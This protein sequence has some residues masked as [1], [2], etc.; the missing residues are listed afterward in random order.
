MEPRWSSWTGGRESQGAL[1][2]LATFGF[3]IQ[4][5]SGKRTLR[6]GDVGW[7]NIAWRPLRRHDF[8]EDSKDRGTDGRVGSMLGVTARLLKKG[9]APAADVIASRSMTGSEPG[10]FFQ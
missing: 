3:G 1:A 6:G 4:P 8:V 9:T 2:W 10:S 5:L 7:E